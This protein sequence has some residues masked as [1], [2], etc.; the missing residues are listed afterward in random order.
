MSQVY[1]IICGPRVYTY[2]GWTFEYPRYSCPAPLKKDGSPRKRSGRVFWG[3]IKR[4]DKLSKARREKYRV[5]G[6]CRS[7]GGPVK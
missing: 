7:F 1:G 6:G 4:F 5:G 3:V 2:L